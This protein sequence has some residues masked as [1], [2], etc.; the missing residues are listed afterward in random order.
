[1]RGSQI[2]NLILLALLLALILLVLTSTIANFVIEYNW[3][4]EVAQVGTW[5]SMLW[6][7][8]CPVRGG[9]PGGF[10][11]VV[12]GSCAGAAL[13]RRPPRGFPPV[14]PAGSDGVGRSGTIVRLGLD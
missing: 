10:H 14:L 5:I 1:M 12:G 2:R 11:R 13:R 7:Q 3:W 4:K 9:R 8:H 6:Y